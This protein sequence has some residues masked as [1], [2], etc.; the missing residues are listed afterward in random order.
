[1]R[2]GILGISACLL[3]L[4]A[5]GGNSDAADGTDTVSPSS[6]SA[7][8]ATVTVTESAKPSC[9]PPS[10]Q[11]ANVLALSWSL[12]VASRG[13]SDHTDMAESFFDDAEELAEE[14]EDGHCEGAA[15]STAALLAYQASL[16]NAYALSGG[17]DAE[18]RETAR[19]GNELL[20][21]MGSDSQFIPPSC[22]GRVDET[23]E[24]DALS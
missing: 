14:F 2:R 18:Y 17:G 9:T 3:A 11:E 6:A 8:T 4:A 21:Q 10:V 5:C 1:M 23:S 7:P 15:A 12:V 16:V 20:A 13:A 19:V 24:C 22:T